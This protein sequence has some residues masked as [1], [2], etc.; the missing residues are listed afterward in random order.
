VYDPFARPEKVK[1][2]EELALVLAV[3]APVSMIVA[4]LPAVPTEPVM[5]QV[6]AVAV[7]VGTVTFA[8]STVTAAPVGLNVYPARVGVTVYDPFTRP[9]RVYAPEASA[10]VAAVDAPLRV[11]VAAPPEVPTLPV[12]LQADAWRL[13]EKVF[14]KPP[15]FAV[16][17]TF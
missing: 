15:A 13:S 3:D 16:K 12:M 2:P 8:P 14:E 1:A 4:P 7:K 9:E 10:V 5:L 6:C 17:T 11:I